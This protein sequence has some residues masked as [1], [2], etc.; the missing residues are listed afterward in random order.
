MASLFAGVW[1]GLIRLPLNLPLPSDNANW[2][3][4][5]GP[6]MVCG[7][8]GTVIGLERAVGLGH[9][10]TYACPLL[11]GLGAA[12]LLAGGT[13]RIPTFLIAAGSAFF[14]LISIQIYRLQSRPHTVVM[15]LGAAAWFTANILWAFEMPINRLI[16]WYIAFLGLVI[17]G[18]RLDLSR[19]QRSVPWAQ[20]VLWAVLAIFATGVVWSN[21]HT[22][23]GL[24]ITGLGLLLIAVWLA[25]FDIVRR[26]I[27][28]PGLPRFMASSLLSGYAWLAVS[29]LLFLCFAPQNSGT[30]YDAAL[31]SFFLGFVFSMIFGHAPIIFP[32]VLALPPVPM[33]N[34][35]YI[36][37]ALL[38]F[39]LLLR[40]SSDL[41]G[42]GEGRQ[43]GGILNAITFVVFLG[44]TVTSMIDAGRKK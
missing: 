7:F 38:H 42:W 28:E 16:P 41:A 24:R 18:E 33:R 23:L 3:T 11:T 32:A 10:W 30:F 15:T 26:T 22:E 37:L 40:L 6:L 29:G 9:P 1:G 2:I 21:Y 5:H 43:L 36:H 8:L 14:V 4:F 13:G 39:S 20:S 27:R 17:L 34:R 31:H 25:R 12:V 35:F 19:F 44:N